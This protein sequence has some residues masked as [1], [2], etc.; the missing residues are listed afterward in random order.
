M[1]P[2]P[3]EHFLA[4]WIRRIF[5]AHEWKTVATF[6][7]RECR[8]CGWARHVDIL[9]ECAKCTRTKTVRVYGTEQA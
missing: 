8:E 3:T 7:K 1:N 6:G 2:M 9:R 5:C 4:A